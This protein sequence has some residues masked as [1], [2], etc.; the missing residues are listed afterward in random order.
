MKFND[1]VDAIW[2]TTELRRIAGAHVVDHRQ[3]SNDELKAAIKKAR[4][5]Y[6]H[7]ETVNSSLDSVI[8]KTTE[9]DLRVLSRLLLVDVLL[10]QY[11]FEL[12]F[13][14]TEE[15][16]LSWEQSV[17]DRSNE[18]ELVDLGCVNRKSPRYHSLDLYRFVLDVAWENEDQTSPDEVNLLRKLRGRLGI[19]ESDH[20][21]IESK[22]GKYPKR[23]NQLHTRTEINEARRRLQSIGLLFAIRRD[24]DDVA[25]DIIPDELARVMRR[26]LKIELRLDSYRALM[27]H[28]P[29]R[30]KAHLVSVLDRS[31]VEYN[32]ADTVDLLVDR[33]IEY[34]SPSQ[35]VSSVSPR[36]GLNNE[37]L[38]AWCRELNETVSG[39]MDERLRR[40]ISHFD[41]LRPRIEQEVDERAN[42]YVY[43]EQLAAREYD[44]LRSQHIIEKDL[45][46]ETKFEQST[47]YLFD[48]KLKHTPLHQAGTNHPDGL[49]SLGSNYVMWDNKSKEIPVSL[50]DHIRQF[51]AYMNDGDKPVPIFLVIGPSFT[52][53]SDSEAVR[54]HAQHFDRNISLI[55]AHE[56]KSLAEEWFSEENKRREEPFPLGMLAGTGRFD[57]ERI[58]KIH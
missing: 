3:L 7:E 42:W 20:R 8:Y 31:G 15:R 14:E 21:L 40:V 36:Y 6:L 25:V 47:E 46:I 41:Q 9:S 24:D 32:P 29:L 16:V 13:S 4:L 53:D 28:K 48:H 18:I 51:D 37:Q 34:V 23:S 12:P 10:N 2:R 38:A 56:L 1:V 57:R 58:G 45:E 17:I 52:P 35:A 43:Y 22:L 33:V 27:D 5:Q 50:K 54:Y 49:L 11:D 44:T 19:T 55:T 39:T 26:I 30:R